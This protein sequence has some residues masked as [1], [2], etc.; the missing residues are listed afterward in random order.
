MSKDL[1][2][3]KV[4][5]HHRGTIQIKQQQFSLDILILN[6]GSEV[7]QVA[8]GFVPI[9]LK[10]FAVTPL[11]DAGQSFQVEFLVFHA[12]SQS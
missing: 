10:A 2:G 3:A 1:F 4:F 12:L 7:N 8:N 11:Q 6:T 9:V 5:L